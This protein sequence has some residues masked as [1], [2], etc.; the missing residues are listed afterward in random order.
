M[1]A[2][3]AQM[4]QQMQ[5]MLQGGVPGAHSLAG[6]NLSYRARFAVALQLSETIARLHACS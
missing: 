3:F 5:L 2:A 6:H 1:M 4:R